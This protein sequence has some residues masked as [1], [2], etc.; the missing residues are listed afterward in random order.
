MKK[1]VLIV[2]MLFITGCTSQGQSFVHDSIQ[3]IFTK[4]YSDSQIEDLMDDAIL[5][6]LALNVSD[7][8]NNVKPFYSYYLPSNIGKKYSDQI[9]SIFLSNNQEIVMNIDVSNVIIERYFSATANSTFSSTGYSE[10]VIYSHTDDYL[11]YNNE[12]VSFN[13]K[14]QKIDEYN[15]FMVLQSDFFV[16]YS[17]TE[18]GYLPF[19][20]EDMIVISRSTKVNTENVLA[21]YS[22]KEIMDYQSTTGDLFDSKVPV[23]GLLQEMLEDDGSEF[24]WTN[25]LFQHDSFEQTLDPNVEEEESVSDESVAEDE[26]QEDE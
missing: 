2:L 3:S 24:D 25:D 4:Q 21:S 10:D 1:I 16:F 17:C 11:N 20:I 23:D 12:T 6:A 9:G 15:Y 19:I 18:A 26:V 22:N 13:V 5:N 7:D 8:Q 14:I